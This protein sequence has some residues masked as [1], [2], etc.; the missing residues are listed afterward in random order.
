MKP[1]VLAKPEEGK[2][3]NQVVAATAP[4]SQR[5]SQEHLPNQASPAPRQNEKREL[6]PPE[7]MEIVTPS[8]KVGA[9]FG[10]LG[11]FTG[12]AAGIIRSAPPALFSVVMGGQMFAL[13][14][15]Y[16]A[17]RM[18]ALRAFGGE[19]EIRPADKVKASTVAGGVA[20][21]VGGVLRGPK[22]IVPGIICFSVFGGAGQLLANAINWKPSSESTTEGFLKSKWSPV[23]FL[24]DEEYQKILKEKLLRVEVEIAIVD[25][26]I[27]ELRTAEEQSK[28]Q[29]ED[30]K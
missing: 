11:L 29:Q 8:L 12:A 4:V 5:Q 10:T 3:V 18:V 28:K 6:L 1:V 27:K 15:S 22:N 30:H 7:L 2:D 21:M 9:T 19:N 16:Y 23:T 14:S 26:N 13:G 25:D 17:S 20:G 24:P